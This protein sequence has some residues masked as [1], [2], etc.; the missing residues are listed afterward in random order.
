LKNRFNNLSGAVGALNSST[1][2]L[3]F[4]NSRPEPCAMSPAPCPLN[5]V[6]RWKELAHAFRFGLWTVYH[7]T[8]TLPL[9]PATC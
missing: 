6:Q 8:C 7:K 3:H 1:K 4:C 5:L 9:N 2:T